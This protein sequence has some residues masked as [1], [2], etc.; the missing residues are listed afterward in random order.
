[1]ALLFRLAP[2]WIFAFTFA[3]DFQHSS[4]NALLELAHGDNDV[5]SCLKGRLSPGSPNVAFPGF[6][7]TSTILLQLYS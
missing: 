5:V 1:V 2:H 4:P 3:Q 6:F 7:L